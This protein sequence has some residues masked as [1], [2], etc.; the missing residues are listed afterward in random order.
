[1]LIFYRD[2][3]LACQHYIC[4]V[5]YSSS[6]GHCLPGCRANPV[7]ISEFSTPPLKESHSR[8]KSNFPVIYMQH[9]WM[10]M[11]TGQGVDVAPCADYYLLLRL[12]AHRVLCFINALC[13]SRFLFDGCR[14]CDGLL[15]LLVLLHRESHNTQHHRAN[16]QNWVHKLS[17]C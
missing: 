6:L 15:V 1:M 16:T 11:W 5:Q 17:F 2:W 3:R 4:F 13:M 9:R 10:W 14:S 8:L 12:P 7:N